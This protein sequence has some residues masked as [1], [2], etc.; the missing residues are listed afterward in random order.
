MTNKTN[1]DFTFVSK[2]EIV[3][4]YAGKSASYGQLV[5]RRFLRNKGAVV[6]A[7][8]LIVIALIAFLA[9]YL[10]Q[11]SPTTPYPS[12]SNLAP[13]TSG[14]WFGTD[15][16]GRDIF[17]RVAAGTSVSLRVALVAMA[18][19]LVI[20][21]SYGLISGYFG[22]KVDLFMQR[23][24]EILSTIPMIIIVTLLVLVMRPGL[25]SIITAMMIVGW[26]NMSRIVR[27]QVLELK[28]R[29]F[30]LSAKTMGEANSKIIFSQ[31]LPNA[32]GQIIT[33]FMLSVPNAIFLE[34]FLAFIGLGVP[35]PLASLG[36]MINDGYTQAIVYPYMVIFP[37]LFLALIMLSFNIIA[38]GLR[39]ALEGS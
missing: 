18:I 35:A 27:A 17:V 37:V 34:A 25:V 8:V 26:I 11:F 22:G 13:G 36:T 10:S 7:I 32:L 2:P 28:T 12:Q 19:D 24:T 16:L 21:T 1:T 3:D 30:V 33:T 23:I 6:S 29:E 4:H 38:D 14:H 5:W 20:G 15:N 9:P 39:D 31:I